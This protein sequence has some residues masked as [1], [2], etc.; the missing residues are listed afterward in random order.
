MQ[1]IYDT[2][3]WAEQMDGDLVNMPGIDVTSDTDIEGTVQELFEGYDQAVVIRLWQ[4]KDDRGA[5]VNYCL[6]T[7][8]RPP[9]FRREEP[10]PDNPLGIFCATCGE[11]CHYRIQDKRWYCDHSHV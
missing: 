10:L 2:W 6:K 9:Q 11:Y 5:P 1:T 8:S 7:W 3:L 4:Q